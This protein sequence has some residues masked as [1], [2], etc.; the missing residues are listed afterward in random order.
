MEEKPKGLKELLAK[1]ADKLVVLLFLVLAVVVFYLGSNL[2][3]NRASETR[4]EKWIKDT[5]EE[6]GAEHPAAAPSPFSGGQKQ[7][8]SD[9]DVNTTQAPSS[10]DGYLFSYNTRVDVERIDPPKEAYM[11]YKSA[12]AEIKSIEVK[13]GEVDVEVLVKPPDNDG[14]KVQDASNE[15]IMWEVK[16][17]PQFSVELQRREPDDKKWTSVATSKVQNP[18]LGESVIL[19]D[20]TVL[21]ERNYIYKVVVSS[22]Y[23][24]SKEDI[25]KNAKFD[26]KSA[27]SKE[28]DKVRTPDRFSFALTE[29][30]KKT[31]DSIPP[32][33]VY[34]VRFK[35]T[36]FDNADRLLYIYESKHSI[37][38]TQSGST[39]SITP[40]NQRIGW[41]YDKKDDNPIP[42]FSGNQ[43]N[44]KAYTEDKK[45]SKDMSFQT[46][47][48]IDNLYVEEK[49]QIIPV[50]CDDKNH[51]VEGKAKETAAMRLVMKQVVHGAK[52]EQDTDT[53]R[54]MTL[55]SPK[56]TYIYVN[57]KWYD[58]GSSKLCE[59]C[60]KELTDAARREGS[61]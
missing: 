14:K 7:F 11:W 46:D 33:F 22:D 45:K 19:K 43:G 1:H 35:I 10:P 58:I 59:K 47:W 13:T 27:E 60:L 55:F 15:F 5:T 12:G 21:A 31:A 16:T 56:S 61:K 38:L 24:L 53:G 6:A 18:K 29:P 51:K 42:D 32:L 23:K 9:W 50:E 36:Q 4:V 54:R 37:I 49:T 48:S 8:L 41:K 39:F 17:V 52:P 30:P 34:D 3:G 44:V 25:Q 20:T 28:S 26:P 40:K 2:A 57:K